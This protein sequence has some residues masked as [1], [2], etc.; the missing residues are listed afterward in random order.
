MVARGVERLVVGGVLAEVRH[1]EV[2]DLAGN[3]IAAQ[4]DGEGVEGEA[5]I[6]VAQLGPDAAR[7]KEIIGN[8]DGIAIR[9]ATKV[10]P[11]IIAAGCPFC[12]TMLTDGV[13]HFN[14]EGSVVVKDV[15]EL[16]AEAGDL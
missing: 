13:K 16:I 10:K 1:Q 9:S 4:S 7:L 11:D 12:N 6:L 15:A 5:G 2:V 8:Y 14:K 3:E